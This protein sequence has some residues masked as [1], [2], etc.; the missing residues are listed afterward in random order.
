M[1]VKDKISFCGKSEEVE[2]GGVDADMCERRGKK[3][4]HL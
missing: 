4:S 1:R 3:E 2:C